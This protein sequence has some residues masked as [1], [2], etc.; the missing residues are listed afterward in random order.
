MNDKKEHNN[1]NNLYKYN[2]WNFGIIAGLIMI[3]V[4]NAVMISPQCCCTKNNK[5]ELIIN[6]NVI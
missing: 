5:K 6:D 4:F 1:N 2:Y 3:I